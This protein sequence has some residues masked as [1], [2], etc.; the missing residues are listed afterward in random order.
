MG[1]RRIFTTRFCLS[2]GA[3]LAVTT[4]MATHRD[5]SGQALDGP[6]MVYVYFP[7]MCPEARV[8]R[9]CKEIPGNARPSF[10][11]MAACSA[12]ADVELKTAGNPR[13][14]ANCLRIHEG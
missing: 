3:A 14:L 2:L 4:V 5:G 9:D 1:M 6:G 12:F 10:D 7:S 8:E 13:L 11:T